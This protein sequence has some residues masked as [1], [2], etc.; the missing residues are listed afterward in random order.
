MPP[1]SP[2]LKQRIRRDY[3][4]GSDAV[5]SLLTRYVAGLPNADL[6]DAERLQ[7]AP[8]L[9]A[10]GDVD[11]LRRALELGLI[12]WRDLLVTAGLA[13]GDWPQVLD[14]ELPA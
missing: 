12:D 13:D 7:A 9:V 8:V 1:L 6:Q 5:I 2:R 14:R 3:G 11:A 4:P 10:A